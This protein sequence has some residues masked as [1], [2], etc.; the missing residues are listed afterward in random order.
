MLAC[1][2]YTVAFLILYTFLVDNKATFE[3]KGLVFLVVLV[4]LC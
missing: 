1:F 3:T 2:A 4:L